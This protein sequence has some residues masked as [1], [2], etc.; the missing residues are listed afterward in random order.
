[1]LLWNSSTGA[2]VIAGQAVIVMRPRTPL[3]HQPLSV[4]RT[5]TQIR[6]SHGTRRIP[7]TV[8]SFRTWRGSQVYAAWDPTFYIAVSK[9]RHNGAA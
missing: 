8:A 5:A 9:Y 7:L 3:R 4:S 6:H 2:K 1:M